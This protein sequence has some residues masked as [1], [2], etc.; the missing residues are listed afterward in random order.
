MQSEHDRRVNQRNL[1]DAVQ[2]CFQAVDGR[3]GVVVVWSF[4]EEEFA[5]F[6]EEEVSH[7]FFKISHQ[8]SPVPIVSNPSSVHGLADK[9]FEG[10]PRNGLILVLKGLGKVHVEQPV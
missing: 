2:E 10:I 5:I 6:V 3:L 4:C 1:V 9:I 7:V 8:H